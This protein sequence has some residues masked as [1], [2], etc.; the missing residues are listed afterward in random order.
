M[1]LCRREYVVK[2]GI[3]DS[4]FSEFALIQ[5]VQK[6]R[7]APF[8]RRAARRV[9]VTDPVGIT[10]ACDPPTAGDAAATSASSGSVT[11]ARAAM[12]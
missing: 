10:V 2:D 5:S 8:Q 7:R 11:L 1:S 3:A 4:I 6:Q 9:Y 12:T